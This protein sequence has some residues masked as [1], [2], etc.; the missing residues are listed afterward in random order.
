M[1][2]LCTQIMVRSKRAQGTSSALYLLSS[3][4]TS[5]T[6]CE[7]L[8]SCIVPVQQAQLEFISSALL[9]PH[10]LCQLTSV[11]AEFLGVDLCFP[12]I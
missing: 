12:L 7:Y 10:G 4:K 5:S 1:T 6:G 9:P 11:E 2:R 8:Y 3:L